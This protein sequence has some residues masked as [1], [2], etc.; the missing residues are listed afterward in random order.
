MDFFLDSGAF[1]AFTKGVKI[2]IIEYCN[3]IKEHLDIITHYAV[4]DVIGSAEETLKNQKIMEAEGL[5]PV[6]CFHYGEDYSYLSYYIDNYDYIA[7]G[8]MVPVHTNDLI[9]WLDT[10]F[11][12]YICDGKGFPKCKTH[13]FGLTTTNLMVRYPWYSVD[14]T[15]WVL[16][17]AFGAIFMPKRKNG[18]WDWL[19]TPHKI[20]VSLRSPDIKTGH[21]MGMNDGEKQIVDKWLDEIGLCMGKSEYDEQNKEIIIEEGVGNMYQL[22]DK[23]NIIY[24]KE[25]EK[26]FKKYPWPFKLKHSGGLF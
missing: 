26:H 10:V 20:N 13:G 8:G 21:Y 2:D 22:R 4:L 12:K 6:P 25:L 7:L 3:F 15:S 23:A 9:P 24:F 16:T 5:S 17:G 11:S 1:S 19:T 14:S 18:K